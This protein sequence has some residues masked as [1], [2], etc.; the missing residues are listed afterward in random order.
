MSESSFAD[1]FM[2]AEDAATR[3]SGGD[4]TTEQPDEAASDDPAMPPGLP[5]TVY[6][7]RFEDDEPPG[8]SR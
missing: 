5:A 1:D 2:H 3:A 7:G 4:P 6:T 8:V